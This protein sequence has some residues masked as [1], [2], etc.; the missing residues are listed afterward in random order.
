MDLDG[1]IAREVAKKFQFRGTPEL[2]GRLAAVAA[3]RRTSMN[4]E[5]REAL[6]N[7]LENGPAT[8]RS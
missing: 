2:H 5:V 3:R 8:G 4:T 1:G 7:F 6:E